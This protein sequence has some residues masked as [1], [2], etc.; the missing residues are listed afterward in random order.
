MKPEQDS[1]LAFDNGEKIASMP[2]DHSNT[3]LLDE[4]PLI[5]NEDNILLD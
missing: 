1:D 4:N 2:I 3:G 5:E